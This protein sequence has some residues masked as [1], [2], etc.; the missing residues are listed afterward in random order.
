MTV[1]AN[2][3]FNTP[4]I[5]FGQVKHGDIVDVDFKVVTD[6]NIYAI[7]PYCGCTSVRLVSPKQISGTLDITKAKGTG[8]GAL[9]KSIKV[10]LDDGLPT[11]IVND[12]GVLMEN[13]EKKHAFVTLLAEVVE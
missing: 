3:F 11:H 10:F 8:T 9:N 7:M 2:T 5:N 6:A 13:Q 1:N 12:E 4:S